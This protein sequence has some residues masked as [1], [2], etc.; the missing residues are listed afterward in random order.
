MKSILVTFQPGGKRINVEAGKT[1]AEIAREAG[2][3]IRLPCGG[4]GL[5]GKCDVYVYPSPAPG[6]REELLLNKSFI[7]K[8]GRLACQCTPFSDV[9]VQIP[10]HSAISPKSAFPIIRES[11][12]ELIQI[13]DVVKSRK[14]IAIDLGSTT[15]AGYLFDGNSLS[16]I[17]TASIENPQTSFGADVITR[18]TYIMENPEGVYILRERA[19]NALNDLIRGILSGSGFDEESIDSIC[20]AGNS[21]MIHILMGLSPSVSVKPPFEM[22]VEIPEELTVWEL[23]LDIKKNIKVKIIPLSS[24]FIGGDIVAGATW[25]GIDRSDEIVMLIDM[26]TNCEILIGNKNR[27]LATSSPAGPAFEGGRIKCGMNALNGAISWV[28]IGEDIRYG[29]IGNGI[30]LGICGSALV[31]I[32]SELLK[33]GIIDETGR[34]RG[35]EDVEGEI[36]AVIASRITEMSGEPIFIIY[37]DDRRIFITQ[38]DIREFQLA[39]AALRTGIEILIKEM[40]VCIDDVG[41]VHLAGSFGNYLSPES[42]LRTG[43]LP[44]FPKERIVSSGNIAGHGALLCM[45]SED[46]SRRAREIARKIAYIHMSQHVNFQDYFL[47]YMNF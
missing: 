16:V 8:G 43:L 7:D 2:I 15:I 30:P 12:S 44:L 18:T 14:G 31:D 39:K 34:I 10:L 29:V 13:P 24:P 4:R 37:E 22:K 28:Y 45:V 5:C 42:A 1:V 35:R 38:G 41:K 47:K 27:M 25:L 33:K 21:V 20:I 9:T 46:A 40:G 36:P 6:L 17:N 19:L 23:G 3:G 32:V 26:G 11:I